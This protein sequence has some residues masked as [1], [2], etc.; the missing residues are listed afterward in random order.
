MNV[1]IGDL[2]HYV[3]KNQRGNG[4]KN[5]TFEQLVHE[6]IKG[7]ETK[8]LYFSEDSLG[9]IDGVVLGEL[10]PDKKNIF[11]KGIL[12]TGVGVMQKFTNKV[13][14]IY[15]EYSL[16]AERHGKC[17]QYNTVAFKRKLHII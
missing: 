7:A 3:R 14:E 17:K 6:F 12:T 10:Q 9:N 11:V 1:M 4:F 13:H 2:V 8:T 16:T 5:W 15:P